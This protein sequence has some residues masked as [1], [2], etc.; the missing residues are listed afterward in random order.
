[1]LPVD[2]TCL[3]DFDRVDEADFLRFLKSQGGIPA[4]ESDIGI[5]SPLLTV[6]LEALSKEDLVQW[7]HR[8][9]RQ[10]AEGCVVQPFDLKQMGDIKDGTPCTGSL[11]LF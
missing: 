7:V 10:L 6:V 1:M 9:P 4:H 3:E 8:E 11:V 2:L 5:A